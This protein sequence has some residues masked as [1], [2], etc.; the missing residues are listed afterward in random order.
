M[1]FASIYFHHTTRMFERILQDVL[2][3]L[4]PDPHALD[5]IDEFLR[6]DDFRVLN[7]LR[8]SP[9]ESARALRER[10]RIYALAAEFN[11][12]S[13]LRAYEKCATALRERFGDATVWAD[14]Q[15]QVLHRLPLGADERRQTVWVE[16]ASG[17]VDAREASDLIAKLSGKAY[18]RKLF[19]RRDSADVR[20][21]RRLCGEI[22]SSLDMS[23]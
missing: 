12:E 8:D 22:I 9:S 20:E 1:M 11:A 17:L 15:S 6:W 14:E 10:I 4:W 23:S 19:V 16:T 18:W 3:E 5:P 7:E 13:D 21:A 2:R